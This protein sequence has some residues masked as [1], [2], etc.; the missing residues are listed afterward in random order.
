MVAD[1]LSRKTVAALS[2]QHSDWRLVDD[3]ALLAQLKAQP[4]LK[5]MI[6]DAQ[7]KDEELQKKVQ[8]VR[9]NDKI[10]FSIREDVSLYFQ[11][12]LCVPTYKEMRKELLHE[13]HNS[14]FTMHPGGNRM[15]QDLKQYYW[16]RGMKRDVTEYVSKCLTC[17]QVIAEHQ[18]KSGLLNPIPI[19][20]WKCDNIDMDFVS[21]LPLMQK[22]HDIVWVIIDRLIKSAHFIPVR[23][24]YSMD[25]LAELY[26]DEIIRMHGVPLSIV[27]DRDLR[28]TSRFWKELQ[29][30][31]GTRLNFSTTFHPQTDGQSER[32]I[33][34]LEDMLRGYVMK[35]TR[36]WDRYVPLMEF[37]YNNSYLASIG[38]TPY[39]ALCGRRC[40]TPVCWT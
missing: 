3:G 31:L 6:I 13:A 16:W 24:D 2:L 36:S 5:Q 40:R 38:M 4:V 8:L 12:R 26:V 20:Q 29:L 15:Y 34:V 35:F 39:E 14:M 11:N 22:K 19:L 10:D 21:G 28:F 17:Q 9:A 33:Q 27:L 30:A 1:A 7:K 37:S 18:V 32:L 23:I 25:R